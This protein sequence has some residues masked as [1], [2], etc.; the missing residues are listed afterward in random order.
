MQAINSESGAAV[1]RYELITCIACGIAFG[2]Q[3][4]HWATVAQCG[5]TLHCPNGHENTFDAAAVFETEDELRAALNDARAEIV[6]LKGELVDARHRA[7]MA[8]ARH[9]TPVDSASAPKSDRRS[10]RGKR[11]GGSSG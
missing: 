8:E 1:V 4:N 3:A 10:H 7:E 11:I 2:V 9:E 5:G 6:R